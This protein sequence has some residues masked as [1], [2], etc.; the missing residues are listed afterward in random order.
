[1][2]N[3]LLENP[4][5]GIDDSQQHWESAGCILTIMCCVVV[6]HNQKNY[7]NSKCTFTFAFKMRRTER[8]WSH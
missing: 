2:A 7:V 1:M 3:I 4:E 8:T 5:N 6:N